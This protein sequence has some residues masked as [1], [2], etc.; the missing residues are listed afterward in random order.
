MN[1]YLIS[2]LGADE[3][4]F[5]KLQLPT[6]YHV[7]HINWI[8]PLSNEK[9]QAYAKRL[10]QQIDTSKPFSL[11]GLSF[12][13]MMAIEIAKIIQPSKTII[14]SSCSMAK[15]LPWHYKALGFIKVYNYLPIKLMKK[16]NKIT[17]WFFGTKNEHEQKILGE[18]IAETDSNYLKWALKMISTWRNKTII[19]NLVHIHGDADR[20]FPIYFI[21]PTITIADGTHMMVRDK[22]DEI[23]MHIQSLLK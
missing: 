11:I 9:I 17:Y 7:R 18:T 12:G 3:R 16:K 23:S 19:P 1:L 13:G 15:Q 22:A 14:L 10:L 20:L 4:A 21:E 6:H 5:E 8:S 2:G